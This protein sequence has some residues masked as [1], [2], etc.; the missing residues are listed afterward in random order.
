MRCEEGLAGLALTQFLGHML[1]SADPES[2]KGQCVDSRDWE[3]H[4]CTVST[5]LL[6][7]SV[8]K[9]DKG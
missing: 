6:L 2:D 8:F 1:P 7:V 9:G 4:S 5:S 3:G